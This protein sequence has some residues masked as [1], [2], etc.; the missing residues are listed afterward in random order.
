MIVELYIPKGKIVGFLVI[1]GLFYVCSKCDR[2]RGDLNYG[3]EGKNERTIMGACPNRA[4]AAC[5]DA[6]YNI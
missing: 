6:L 3:D 4:D 2:I 5:G 1:Y